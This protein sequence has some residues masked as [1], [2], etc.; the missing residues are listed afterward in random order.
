MTLTGFAV[1][2]SSGRVGLVVVLAVPKQPLK[3]VIMADQERSLARNLIRGRLLET[4]ID[5]NLRFV[6]QPYP[7]GGIERSPS[8]S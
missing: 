7:D 2:A 4:G 1:E 5:G 8:G 3:L 6:R